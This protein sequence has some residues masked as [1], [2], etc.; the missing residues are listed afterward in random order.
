MPV[1]HNFKNLLKMIECKI[2]TLQSRIIQKENDICKINTELDVIILEQARLDKKLSTLIPSGVLKRTDL[3]SG[4]RQY[5]ILLMD[6]NKLEE[7]KEQLSIALAEIQEA[8][9][10]EEKNLLKINKRNHKI[11][12]YTQ[13]QR[14]H[15]LRMQDE[16]TDNDIQEVAINGAGYRSKNR[17]D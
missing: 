13:L 17:H 9:K 3:F 15:Y 12:H 4:I 10:A 11:S 8:K 7:K 1:R 2:F 6:K 5:E 16:R 14:I